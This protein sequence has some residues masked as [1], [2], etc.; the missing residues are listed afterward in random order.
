LV[1]AVSKGRC[2]VTTL[3][4]FRLFY[5]VYADRTPEIRH[6]ARDESA[7]GGGIARNHHKPGDVLVDLSL[8]VEHAERLFYEIEAEKEGW[9]V[10]HLE[11]QIHTM[12][13]AR[14]IKS[15]DKAGVLALATSGQA[16]ER[17]VDAIKDPYVL[18]FLELPEGERLHETA[19]ESAIIAACAAIRRSREPIGV[20]ILSRWARNVPYR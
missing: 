11:R 18:D 13:F 8:A 5:Q 2:T 9:S 10:P 4:Y 7:G 12:L 6:Q 15:R 14:L 20:P 3:R 1:N 19:M 17:P 16:I